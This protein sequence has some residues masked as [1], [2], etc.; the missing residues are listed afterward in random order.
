MAQIMP[1]RQMT[2]SASAKFD[3]ALATAAVSAPAWVPSLADMT[4][5]FVFLSAVGGFVLICLR[6]WRA[7]K[8][9]NDPLG[10]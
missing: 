2:H 4:S 6:I 7:W 8:R 10:E 5:L 3:A 1:W 9:R